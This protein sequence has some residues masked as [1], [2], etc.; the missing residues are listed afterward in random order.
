MHSVLGAA[1]GTVLEI[2]G[3]ELQCDN[4][5]ENEN[6]ITNAKAHQ[7]IK[8]PYTPHFKNLM[9]VSLSILP[10]RYGP[11]LLLWSLVVYPP[12]TPDSFL[13]LEPQALSC[14]SAFAVCPFCLE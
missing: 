11:C 2:K 13:V 4:C 12:A 14:L 8:P 5:E 9:C 10:A 1:G 7:A 6:K 3:T